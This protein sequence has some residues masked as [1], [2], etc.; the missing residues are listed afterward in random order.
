MRS[1]LT[2]T[3]WKCIQY[4]NNLA[5]PYPRYPQCRAI[6]QLSQS[7]RVPRLAAL[8]RGQCPF[9]AGPALYTS[10]QQHRQLN[11]E[12]STS[13]PS[14]SKSPRVLFFGTG[15]IGSVYAYLLSRTIPANSIYTVC[16][17]NYAHA[18][19][20][21]FTIN[22]TIWGDNLHVHPQVVDSVSSAVASSPSE[23]FDYVIVTAKSIESTPSIPTLIRP[24]V[25]AD[26]TI[27]LIQNGIDIEPIYAQEFPDSTIL[28]C[29]IYLPATQTS[30]GVITHREI[31]YL[32][33][34]TYPATSPTSVSSPT[35]TSGQT[36][37]LHRDQLHAEAFTQLLTASGATATLHADVQ[38]ER[39]RKLLVNAAWNPVCALSRSR[40]AAFMAST[41]DDGAEVIRQLMLEVA[42]IANAIG[43][44]DLGPDQVDH[45][46]S[47]AK[48]RPLPGVE[49]SMLA[50]V[51]AGRNM[52]VEAIVG[53]ALR[54]AQRNNVH[55]PL[56]RL[57]YSL[58]KAL[59]DVSRRDRER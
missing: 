35:S 38:R 4:A 6:S 25:G 23:P 9:A 14:P 20:H 45:Q 30:P 49:P 37:K 43:Y 2:V 1:R 55:T 32:H 26:T 24:A 27:V 8:N 7:S 59:D 10:Q 36:R 19:E 5:R 56:L 13:S 21:G 39:W 28:S 11:R 34:G 42:S 31:E 17:S 18:R 57:V 48:A 16:R 3:G 53:N 41:P 52:E 33:L 22:S 46:I 50:D 47:R 54:I 44:A 51:A 29:V 40:D 58:V 15:A 12:M